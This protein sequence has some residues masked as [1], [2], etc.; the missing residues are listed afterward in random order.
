MH[1]LGLAL[2]AEGPTDYHFLCPL[3]RRLCEDICTR[4][5]SELV[6]V[7]DV[8]CLDH[9]VA[10]RDAGRETRVFAAAE[11]AKGAWRVLFVH[12]DG[13][14]D[15]V[16]AHAQQTQPAID[17]VRR[18]LGNSGHGVAVV[19][20]RETEAWAIADGNALRD[21]FGAI[22]DDNTL[23][24]PATAH[25]AESDIDPKATLHAAFF[26]TQPSGRRKRQGVAPLLDALG[27][28]V[29]LARLRRL[30][31]FREMEDELTHA[32]QALSIVR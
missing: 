13:G 2:Y 8:L 12:A 19:P 14:G 3:L 7:S 11:A 17:L 6:E 5:A 32:L 16:R 21:V 26:S 15:P 27:E 20:V 23:Q 22:L 25:Q 30:G 18:G 10:V 31:A 1:Y 28:R 29:S 24:L 9:P 4:D